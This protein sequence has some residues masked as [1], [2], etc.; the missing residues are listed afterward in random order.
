[1]FIVVS[2]HFVIDLVQKLLDTSSYAYENDVALTS[3]NDLHDKF[4]WVNSY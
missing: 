3:N 2:V 4:H 1:M